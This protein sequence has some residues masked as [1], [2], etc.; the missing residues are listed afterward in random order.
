MEEGRS[1]IY[2]DIDD[3]ITAIIGK[4]EGAEADRV[5]LVVPKRSTV[6]QSA[7]NLKLL[8]KSAAAAGKEPIMITEDAVITKL[9]GGHGILVAPTLKS[10]PIVPKVGAPKRAE[11]PSDVIEGDEAEAIQ[12]DKPKAVGAVATAAATTPSAAATAEPSPSTPPATAVKPTVSKFKVPDFDRFKK[13]FAL[14]IGGIVAFGLLVWT[15]FFW[16]PKASIIIEGQTEPLASAF[17]FTADTEAT[18]PN[19]ESD[20]IPAQKVETDKTE[21]KTFTATGE[22]DIGTKATGTI[23]V[24]NCQTSATESYAAGTKFIAPNGK[25]FLSDSG[26]SVPGATVSGGIVCGDSGAIAVSAQANGADYNQAAGTYTSPSFSGDYTISGSAMS[27]GSSKVVT[28]VTKG[29]IAKAREDLLENLREGVKEDLTK[30]IDSGRYTLEVTF[31]ETVKKVTADPA[32]GQ[33]AS[34]GQLTLEVN[35]SLLSVDKGELTELFKRNAREIANKNDKESF[36]IADGGVADAQFKVKDHP[37]A[38]ST[39]INVTTEALLGPDID[40]EDLKQQAG[41]KKLG[42]V[43]NLAKSYPG[44]TGAEVKFSP[45]W[46]RKVPTN[47]SHVTVEIK[48]PN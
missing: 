37:V 10:E 46:V 12:L 1:L 8:K 44:V 32:A 24:E 41:G 38:S 35:Y 13:R 17:L 33:E 22:K 3:D 2:L 45:F 36:G 23:E 27:G 48:L 39:R 26:F 11:L 5:A 47:P 20:L 18:K 9:A 15:L 29:D 40:F 19:Y 43:I 21:T 31:D 42:D 6:L 4:V 28:V 25:A 30:Q 16:L 34:T 7:V 14:A